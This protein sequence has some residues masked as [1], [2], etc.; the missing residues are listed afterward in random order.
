MAAFIL[1]PAV[2]QFRALVPID[3]T[4]LLFV[5]TLAACTLVGWWAGGR[6]LLAIAWIALAT[7]VA[8]LDPRANDPFHNL[9]R[10]WSLVLAGSFGLV[11]LLGARRAFFPRAM[12]AL[13]MAL[14]LALMMSAL[15]PVTGAHMNRAM[16]DELTRRNAETMGAVNEF[17][18]KQPKE[19]S[20]LVARVPRLG[21]MPAELEQQLTALTTAGR[22]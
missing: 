20:D 2:P 4:M 16:A 14:A 12:I 10:G 17:V 13:T 22:I 7:W 11:C 18:G 1:I 21:E 8:M 5:P 15:G 9:A 3:Q 6:M 19:W